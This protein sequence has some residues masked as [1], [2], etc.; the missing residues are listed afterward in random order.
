[1]AQSRLEKIGT[2]Y[3]RVTGL[4][5]SKAISSEQI[6]LWYPIY[7]AFP[8]K[9]EP[10]FD[11]QAEVK[12]IRKILYEEDVVRAKYFK[13]YGNWEVVNL[14]TNEKSTAQTFVDKYM[15]LSNSREFSD[16]ELWDRTVSALELE[17]IRLDGKLSDNENEK[18]TKPVISFQDLF[19]TETK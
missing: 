13:T 10:R 3:S 2:I 6:P 7:E 5:K 14:F 15:E 17:G 18:S 4:I 19:K 16:N 12:T 1:M 9:Y 8:P 11:R